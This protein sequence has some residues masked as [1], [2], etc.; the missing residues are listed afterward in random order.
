M[1][2]IVSER[3]PSLLQPQPIH[4]MSQTAPLNLESPEAAPPLS[5]PQRISLHAT[6]GPQAVAVTAAAG[7][8]TLTYAELERQSNQLAH[9]LASS[10]VGREHLVGL[11]L[12][13]S[14]SFIVA[15]LAALRCGAAYLPLDPDAPAG[16]IAFML[17]DAGVSAVVTSDNLRERLPS[18]PWPVVDMVRDAALIRQQAPQNP[19]TEIHPDDLAYVIYTSG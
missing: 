8:Q 17:Q 10:G 14:P 18:G 2:K 12:K 9:Y 13:R 5:I 16:R 4:R 15:A 7:S 11:Y 6:T 19:K 1:L 3:Q